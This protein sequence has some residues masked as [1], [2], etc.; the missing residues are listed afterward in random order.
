MLGKL[1]AVVIMI[2]GVLG[3]VFDTAGDWTFL[4][5]WS[6]IGGMAVY[7]ASVVRQKKEN[8]RKE[9]E[10]DRLDLEPDPETGRYH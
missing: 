1:I 9:R 6:V 7:L 10:E 3:L 5:M 8:A 2:L 4:M